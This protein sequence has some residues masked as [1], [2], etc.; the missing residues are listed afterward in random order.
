MDSRERVFLSLDHKEPDRVPTD[1]WIST[2]TKR[3][4]RAVRGE[5]YDDFLNAMDIDLRYIDGPAYVGPPLTPPPEAS[6]VDIFGVPRNSVDIRMSGRDGEHSETYKEVVRHP[7]QSAR[8]VDEILDYEGWP[9][10]DWFDFGG[11]EE[12]CERIRGRGRVAVFMG[13]RL[14]RLAQLKP[15]MYLRG[16]EQIFI[17]MAV[18]SEMS[19]VLFDRIQLF[20]MEYGR[21]ILE[22][23]GGKL[24]IL[25]TGDDFGSQ[26]GL[27]VSPDLWRE[28]LKEGFSEYVRL[29]KSFGVRVMHHSC[30][31]VYPL[32]PDLIDCGL[33]ILQSLQPE[34]AEMDP[35]RLKQEFG[36][37]L[38]FQGGISIQE[39]R[40]RKSPHEVREHVKKVMKALAP[41]GGYI[42]C[43]SHNIQADTPQENIDALFQA[44]RDFG[45]Y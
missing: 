44:Y 28:Q 8:S 14:V 40:P 17:D 1:C 26:T 19:Q 4:I 32:I 31:S 12:Q 24:D 21:R 20:Y 15:A 7:L 9:S 23:A 10:P 16:F 25:C 33:D 35:K 43:T 29:G 3:K 38:S 45:V 39:V 41:G 42:A 27:L 2:G 37:D 13:D 30:G 5:S 22:A 18:D 34:A 6:D 36:G 11:I